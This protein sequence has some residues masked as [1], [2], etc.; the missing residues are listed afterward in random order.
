MNDTDY[1]IV[2][3]GITG[4]YCAYELIKQGKHNIL[5]IEASDRLGGRILSEKYN[6]NN[7]ELGAGILKPHHTYLL[8]L[9]KELNLDKTLT[10]WVSKSKYIHINNE[11]DTNFIFDMTPEKYANIVS[12]LNHILDE[13]NKLDPENKVIQ[14]DKIRQYSLFE[15]IDFKYNYKTAYMMELLFGY[16]DDFTQNAIDGIRMLKRDNTNTKMHLQGGFIT[17]IQKLESILL[18][19]NII[20]QLNTSFIDLYENTL[21]KSDYKYTYKYNN[22]NADHTNQT[23]NIIFTI[24]KNKLLSI[25]Y[26]TKYNNTSIIP[27]LNSVSYKSLFRVYMQ[28]PLDKD[29]KVWFEDLDNI[30][31]N[32][33]VRQIIPINKKDGIVMIYVSGINAHLFKIYDSQ[34]ILEDKIL[35]HLELI[36]KKTIPKPLKVIKKYWKEAT[37]TWKPVYN[38]NVISKSILQPHPDQ[39]IYILGETYSKEQQWLNGSCETVIDFIK[40]ISKSYY[41]LTIIRHLE[42]IDQVNIFNDWTDKQKLIINPYLSDMTSENKLIKRLRNTKLTKIIC[43]PFLRCVQTAIKV[44]M[45]YNIKELYIDFNLSE[46]NNKK[47]LTN[48]DSPFN[49][50]EVYIS[51]KNYLDKY[52][53]CHIKLILLDDTYKGDIY[54]DM[55]NYSKRL[56]KTFKKHSENKNVLLVTHGLSLLWSDKDLFMDYGQV[57]KLPYNKLP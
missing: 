29:N 42:R 31:T 50:N 46:L 39:T 57:Y 36:F 44:C 47:V 16:D 53:E 41:D 7:L 2:G 52:S 43:S 40:L 18:A 45:A 5:I 56:I 8:N 28:F 9:I 35:T 15:Y 17:L 33:M 49:T 1:V 6:G 54:E 32:T 25:N 13:I 51:T 48:Y 24:P 55:I 22:M 4:L 26:L 3:G 23:N 37:H 34:H 19:H 21:I 38:S 10:S 12:E 20:I 27:L 14:Q 11:E 30:I